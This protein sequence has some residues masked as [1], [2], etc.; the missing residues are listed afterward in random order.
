MFN[1]RKSTRST[2]R[3]RKKDI[4]HFLC[5]QDIEW[6]IENENIHILQTRPI[7][8]LNGK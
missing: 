6:A 4:K 3:I 5:P 1:E 7:T 8:T 2:N